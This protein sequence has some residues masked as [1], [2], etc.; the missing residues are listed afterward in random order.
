MIVVFVFI[1]SNQVIMQVFLE[2][3][4]EKIMEMIEPRLL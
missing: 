1:N 4:F 2:H 3:M